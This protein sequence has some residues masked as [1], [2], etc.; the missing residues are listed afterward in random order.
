MVN[1][2]SDVAST[3]QPAPEPEAS[4]S[5]SPPAHSTPVQAPATPAAPD[6]VSLGIASEPDGA[7][8]E[9]DGRFVGNAPIDVE[10]DP[11][12][13]L[14]SLSL[15]GH[16][17]WS[18]EME[19]VPGSRIS[20]TLVPTPGMFVSEQEPPLPTMV[21]P[22]PVEQTTVP[23]GIPGPP[24]GVTMPVN[25]VEENRPFVLQPSTALRSDTEPEEASEPDLFVK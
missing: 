16:Q 18:R 6:R 7:E 1:E 5:V 24:P 22:P 21:P 10:V 14:I 19:V 20:A 4:V 11:G 8:V 15:T 23:I 25:V 17:P 3:P 12:V 9:L 2:F 13:H